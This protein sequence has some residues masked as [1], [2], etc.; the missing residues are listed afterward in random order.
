MFKDRIDRLFDAIAP[1]VNVVVLTQTNAVRYLT[2]SHEGMAV[3]RRGSVLLLT[4]RMVELAVKQS[5]NPYRVVTRENAKDVNR[6]AF[7]GAIKI[8]YLEGQTTIPAQKDLKKRCG[9]KPL[10]D[11]GK[12]L[13]DLA[14]IKDAGEIKL[15]RKACKIA[16]DTAD[17]VPGMLK[18]GMTE[19][20]LLREIN[21]V[22]AELGAEGNTFGGIVGFGAN[23]AHPHAVAEHRKLKK[24]QFVMVDYGASV[25]G[26][27]SDITRTYCFGKASAK[28]KDT[29]A[30]CHETHLLS[31]EMTKDGKDGGEI[32]K[33]VS[34]L[35]VAKGYPEFCHSIGHGLGM[36]GGGF[37][38]KP[39]AVNT[40]EPGIYIQG[41]GGVR[42]E[43]DILIKEGGKFDLLTKSPRDVLIEV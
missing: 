13:H 18:E 31:F 23:T 19:L 4:H 10:V 1:D 28:Q 26:Y 22:M 27:G 33:A 14:A 12:A 41:F 25:G 37:V 43:D 21:Y 42:I 24:G 3:L 5:G 40:I 15:L 34:E 35:M 6:E 17:R 39:G 36:I 7:E 2:G 9:R 30:V 11:I 8:G 16:S 32:N 29:Y 20:E 38:N